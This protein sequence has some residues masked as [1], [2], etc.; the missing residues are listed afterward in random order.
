MEWPTRKTTGVHCLPCYSLLETYPLHGAESGGSRDTR[1]LVLVFLWS[2]YVAPIR[3][4]WVHKRFTNCELSH[5]SECIPGRP[6][7]VSPMRIKHR[8]RHRAWLSRE[9]GRSRGNTSWTSEKAH[10]MPA[11]L[12]RIDDCLKGE[13]YHAAM[14]CRSLT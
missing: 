13:S 14:P 5:M 10:G 12:R 4:R 7:I 3:G 6:T 1:G 8:L 11:R 9:R 2:E